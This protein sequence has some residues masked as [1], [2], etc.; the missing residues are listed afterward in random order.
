[1]ESSNPIIIEPILEVDDEVHGMEF[2]D[3]LSRNEF[4]SQQITNVA[5]DSLLN[6]SI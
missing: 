1:M 4:V 5:N 3:W 6:V 2:I